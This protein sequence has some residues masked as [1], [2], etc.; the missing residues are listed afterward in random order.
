MLQAAWHAVADA[1][2]LA[3]RT[4]LLDLGC[5]N[6]GFCAFASERGAIVHGIDAEPDSIAQAM[7]AV[8]GGEFRLGMMET[9]PWSDAS[10]DVVTTFNAMQY[11][12]DPEL[13]MAE[14]SR[15]VRIGGRLAICKWGPPAENQFFAFLAAV[16][17]NGVRAQPPF[18]DD[19]MQDAIRAAHLDVLVTGEVP[20]A[21]EM[22]DDAALEQSLSRAG[23]VPELGA[24]TE[25]RS[26]IAAAA[27]YRQADG[28]YRF[29]NHL[30]FWVLRRSR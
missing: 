23:I 5:G 17:A 12:L 11:A 18:G 24:S 8:P 26:V 28:S 15:V 6:G 14:A 7:D 10:F 19:P 20:A 3:E 4:S 9:L 30:R 1:A 16:G 29:D 27:P 21:I 2:G 22:S 25:A 13:A